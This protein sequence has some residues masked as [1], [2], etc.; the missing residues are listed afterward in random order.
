[1]WININTHYGACSICTPLTTVARRPG[2]SIVLGQ[3]F[4]TV[5]GAT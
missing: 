5:V 3:R 1:M 2:M 4:H